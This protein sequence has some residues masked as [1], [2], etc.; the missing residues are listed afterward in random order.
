MDADANR[1]DVTV[2]PQPIRV[3]LGVNGTEGLYGDRSACCLAKVERRKDAI[4]CLRCGNVCGLLTDEQK[5][6]I[7]KKA[8]EA[9]DRL[10]KTKVVVVIIYKPTNMS[11]SS[12]V[13]IN[14]VR[15]YAEQAIKAFAKTLGKEGDCLGADVDAVEFRKQFVI[16]EVG[17][18]RVR[19]TTLEQI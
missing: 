11:T 1:K 18:K 3:N 15:A 10:L 13:G 14:E 4:V 19:T 12:R 8:R 7:N 6:E 9:I 17:D 5:F 16:V 2:A